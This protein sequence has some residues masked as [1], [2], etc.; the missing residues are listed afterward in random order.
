MGGRSNQDK[1]GP[2]SC[3]NKIQIKEQGFTQTCT[4]ESLQT[5][6]TYQS[7][8]PVLTGKIWTPSHTNGEW[9]CGQN[10][11]FGRLDSI[12]LQQG[13]GPFWNATLTYTQPLSS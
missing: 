8:E 11:T 1:S 12:N 13:D 3:L 9:K 2:N 6:I 4:S 5:T 10:Y 7:R